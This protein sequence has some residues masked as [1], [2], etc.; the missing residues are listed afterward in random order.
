MI[1]IREVDG[2]AYFDLLR[3]MNG[4]EPEVFPPLE[5]RHFTGGSWWVAIS[6][7]GMAVGFAG[8]VK[9]IPFNGYVYMK[10]AYVHPDYRGR[11]IQQ[12]FL[13]LREDK[14][15]ELGYLALVAECSGCNTPSRCNFKRAGFSECSPEQAWGA[16]GSVYFIKRLG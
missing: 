10:R 8:M 16:P 9:M 6:D 2:V 12:E 5:I 4:F 15:R 1:D 7:D 13:R 14:A 11:G 3:E